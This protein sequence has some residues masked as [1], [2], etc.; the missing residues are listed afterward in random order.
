[1]KSGKSIELSWLTTPG[2][3]S[4][5]KAILSRWILDFHSEEEISHEFSIEVDQ[6]LRLIRSGFRKMHLAKED[7]RDKK[8]ARIVHYGAKELENKERKG[9]KEN[10]SL[11]KK[12]SFSKKRKNKRPKRGRK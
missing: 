5:E 4:L 6:V 3:S 10:K 11:R 9:S 2:L 7:D 1:L 8:E 12:K